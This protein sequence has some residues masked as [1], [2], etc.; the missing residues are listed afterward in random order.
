MY[1]NF[2]IPARVPDKLWA[3]YLNEV[4]RSLDASITKSSVVY[5]F[6]G[7]LLTE[8]VGFLTLVFPLI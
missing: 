6:F 2:T 8:L 5:W 7:G 4:N 3:S 1:E